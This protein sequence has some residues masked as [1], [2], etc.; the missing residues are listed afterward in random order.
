VQ[1]VIN[2]VLASFIGKRDSET[3]PD[4]ENER[5]QSVNDFW[6]C[7]LGNLRG[8]RLQ[9]VINEVLAS[10]IGKTDSEKLPAPS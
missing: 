7:I 2:E 5:Q 8:E 9:I 1:I 6:S 4:H 10:F 3:L